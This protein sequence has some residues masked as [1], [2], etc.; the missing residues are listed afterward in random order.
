MQIWWALY[1]FLNLLN[2]SIHVLSVFFHTG[3]EETIVTT[4]K[5]IETYRED[6]MQEAACALK[7]AN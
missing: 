4:I 1:I 6:E 7:W 3:Q 2:S 5:L